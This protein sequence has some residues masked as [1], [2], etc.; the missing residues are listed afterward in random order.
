MCLQKNKSK[1]MV[2]KEE[3]IC[4]TDFYCIEVLEFFNAKWLTYWSRAI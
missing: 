4:L 3:Q 1:D 2:Q